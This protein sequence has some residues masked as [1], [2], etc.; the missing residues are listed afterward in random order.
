MYCD[1][2]KKTV[3]LERKRL[4]MPA[5]V[6]L[7][8]VVATGDKILDV[9]REAFRRLFAVDHDEKTFRAE[10][11]EQIRRK[12][13][14]DEIWPDFACGQP[15]NF[16]PSKKMKTASF[17]LFLLAF[18]KPNTYHLADGSRV[19]LKVTPHNRGKYPLEIDR[20]HQESNSYRPT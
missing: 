11:L 14:G 18:C 2:L 20:I 13:G 16:F 1:L 3:G 12:R 10:F 6:I 9:W 8:G 5:E 4:A 19:P 7:D 17:D 15:D